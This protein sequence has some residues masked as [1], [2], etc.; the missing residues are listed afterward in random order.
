MTK[1]KLYRMVSVHLDSEIERLQPGVFKIAG[2]KI[3]NECFVKIHSVED[4]GDY[5]YVGYI[6]Y[7]KDKDRFKFGYSRF[8]KENAP[9]FSTTFEEV[10]C[11]PSGDF[12]IEFQENGKSFTES[13]IIRNKKSASDAVQRLKASFAYSR[14]NCEIIHV[15]EIWI[16]K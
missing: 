6:P 1:D 15:E 5:L 2:G 11:V 12:A 13:T 4:R 8:Y 14:R 9:E 7:G 16:D 10:D 3:Y